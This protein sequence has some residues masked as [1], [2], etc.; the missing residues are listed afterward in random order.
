MP[1]GVA[2]APAPSGDGEALGWAAAGGGDVLLADG[3]DAVLL[4]S[5]ELRE[6][7]V[8]IPGLLRPRRVAVGAGGDIFVGDARGVVMRSA[9]GGALRTLLSSPSV[10]EMAADGIG[11]LYVDD[12]QRVLKWSP[13]PP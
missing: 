4:W 5:S 12:G 6:A 10:A 11:N 2:P 9:A 3:N 8:L 13:P 1:P 7:S